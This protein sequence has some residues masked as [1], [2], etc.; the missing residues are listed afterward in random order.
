VIPHKGRPAL[1]GAVSGH[2]KPRDGRRRRRYRPT[3]RGDTVSPSFSRSSSAIRSSPQVG[4]ARAM[5]TISRRRSGG[6]GGRPGRDVQRQ[7]NR[8]P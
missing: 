5:V 7:T 4:F 6:I 3:V 2:L 1:G 8:Q